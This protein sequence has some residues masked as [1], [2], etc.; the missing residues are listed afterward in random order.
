MGETM[1]ARNLK[2]ENVRLQSELPPSG[3]SKNNDEISI[4]YDE[5]DGVA[6]A[7]NQIG[8]DLCSWLL[9]LLSPR[10]IIHPIKRWN[11]SLSVPPTQYI[12]K[13]THSTS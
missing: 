6:W 11:A 9:I 12:S 4:E 3:V 8:F 1:T 5:E 10:A 13:M 7:S 2:L